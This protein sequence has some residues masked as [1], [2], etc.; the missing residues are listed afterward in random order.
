MQIEQQ[1]L[2]EN[3]FDENFE[4][5]NPNQVISEEEDIFNREESSKRIDHSPGFKS[6]L[7]TVRDLEKNEI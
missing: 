6:Y 2:V 3:I 1:N 7:N 4:N 5:Q